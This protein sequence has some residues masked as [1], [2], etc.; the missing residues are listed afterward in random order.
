MS[1]HKHTLTPVHYIHDDMQIEAGEFKSA[2]S[3]AERFI[4]RE[5]GQEPEFLPSKLESVSLRIPSHL[6]DVIKSNATCFG[7]SKTQFMIQALE[8]GINEIF[9]EFN[10]HG[11]TLSTDGYEGDKE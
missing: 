8:V 7:M 2:S 9:E 4:A 11:V 1:K 3:F 5:S 10:S 6:H